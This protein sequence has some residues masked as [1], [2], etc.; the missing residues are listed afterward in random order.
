MNFFGAPDYLNALMITTLAIRSSSCKPGT[1]FCKLLPIIV[2][3]A[4]LLKKLLFK[5]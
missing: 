5:R 1:G 4:H 3:T 2:N